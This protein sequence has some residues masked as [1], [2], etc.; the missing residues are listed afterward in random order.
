[1]IVYDGGDDDLLVA[2]ITSH[3]GRTRYDIPVA[4]WQQAGL[5]LASIV[6]TE[7]LAT[8]AKTTVIRKLGRLSA[9]DW[10]VAEGALQEL[11]RA[12]LVR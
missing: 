5:R 11:F 2:P 8:I 7:K 9:K 1:M 3:A 12:I 4:E 6:R 10:A